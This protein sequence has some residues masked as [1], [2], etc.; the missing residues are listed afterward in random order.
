[1]SVDEITNEI[2]SIMIDSARVT[3]PR[4]GKKINKIVL[5]KNKSMLLISFDHSLVQMVH[6]SFEVN[7]IISGGEVR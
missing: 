3:F 6:S 7:Q 1:M 5:V 2:C 4:H